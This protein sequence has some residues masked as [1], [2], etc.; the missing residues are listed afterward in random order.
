MRKCKHGDVINLFIGKASFIILL[1]ICKNI[2]CGVG[3]MIIPYRI[4]VSTILLFNR[5]GFFVTMVQVIAHTRIVAKCCSLCNLVIYIGAKVNITLC[6]GTFE[7]IILNC[8]DTSIKSLCGFYLYLLHM[9]F[10]VVGEICTL[11]ISLSAFNPALGC[12]FSN[13]AGFII[14]RS[15]NV[16]DLRP[17]LLGQ[18]PHVTFIHIRRRF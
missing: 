14:M 2:E 10:I 4:E 7:L 1:S 8:S 16:I 6:I 9:R 3:A 18:P 12:I 15:N 13:F 17:F 5:S 11:I